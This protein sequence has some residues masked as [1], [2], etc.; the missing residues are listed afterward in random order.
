MTRVVD[1]LPP[2]IVRQQME[3]SR[4]Q[5]MVGLARVSELE[6]DP[7]ASSALLKQALPLVQGPGLP[8]ASRWVSLSA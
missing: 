6:D 3:S 8:L 5:A 2:G 4:V 1:A 7:E